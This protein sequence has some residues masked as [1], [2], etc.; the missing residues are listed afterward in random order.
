MFCGVI[1]H[2][3]FS[4]SCDTG[5]IL[6]CSDNCVIEKN[7][8][9]S[10]T[11]IYTLSNSDEGGNFGSNC[12]IVYNDLV[13]CANIFIRSM[14]NNP[15][16]SDNFI[17]QVSEM[18]EDAVIFIGNTQKAI[19]ERNQIQKSDSTKYD[20][21]FLDNKLQFLSVTDNG[22][23]RFIYQNKYKFENFNYFAYVDGK[24]YRKQYYFD[25]NVQSKIFIRTDDTIN[26]NN[27]VLSPATGG[28]IL[29]EGSVYNESAKNVTIKNNCFVIPAG[30][31]LRFCA[32]AMTNYNDSGVQY[33]KYSSRNLMIESGTYIRPASPNGFYY[34]C[35]KSG[36]TGEESVPYDTNIGSTFYDGT[37]Q[38][39][40]E[41]Y[42]AEGTFDIDIVAS[43]AFGNQ[44]ISVNANQGE[45]KL[46]TLSSYM[47]R[48]AVYENN[49]SAGSDTIVTVKNDSENDV[50][51]SKIL[52][53]RK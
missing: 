3:S 2:N 22:R 24:Y 6:Y 15:Y 49:I 36:T 31:T 16:I 25:R 29:R 18:S 32:I 12:K 7:R 41:G 13:N 14:S 48:Y 40:C 23:I 20:V 45:S 11:G 43:S 21:H 39:R 51:I 47:K 9:S 27:L 53:V 37:A 44:N 52:L 17:E 28:L 42:L 5:I 26:E 19:I 35:V 10:K 30:E 50:Y 46:I 4:N 8:I 38:L 1:S 33:P 34:F